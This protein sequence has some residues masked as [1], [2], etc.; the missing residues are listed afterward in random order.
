[1]I[2]V[3]GLRR[4]LISLGALAFEGCKCTIAGGVVKV[5]K[6]ALV[7]MKVEMVKKSLQVHMGYNSSWN[8]VREIG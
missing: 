5:I 8:S 2:H 3:L 7:I 4:N 1:M 6:G